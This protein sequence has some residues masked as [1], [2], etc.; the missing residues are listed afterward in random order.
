[1][2]TTFLYILF[3]NAVAW[4]EVIPL[5]VT[6]LSSRD[7]ISVIQCWQLAS[8]PEEARS[9]MNY[10]LGDM[11][12]ATWSIIQPRT[13]VGEAWAPNVLLTM[14]LNGLIRVTAPA[15]VANESSSTPSLA[16]DS[17]VAGLPETTHTAYL[18]PGSVVSSMVIAADIKAVSTIRGHFTEFPSDEATVLVQ[19]PFRGGKA[20]EHKI[21]YD[22]QCRSGKE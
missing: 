8:I 15:P 6:A 10:D 9:A 4:G 12:M 16:V 13:T 19:I 22:G 11:D 14:V 1:M 5:N 17:T 21:L 3:L 20:P 2:I 7:G 18:M